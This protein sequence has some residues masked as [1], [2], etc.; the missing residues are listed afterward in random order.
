MP[1]S[2]ADVIILVIM[3]LSGLFA[4]LRGFTRE[5]LTTLTIVLTVLGTYWAF[6]GMSGVIDDFV[7]PGWLADGIAAVALIL[8]L[9]GVFTFLS[10]LLVQ[11]WG[12][13][14]PGPVD[15]TMG[16]IF[17]LARGFILVAL[18]YLFYGWT[19][20]P[21]QRPA[22]ITNARFLPLIEDTNEVFVRFAEGAVA[23]E[24]STDKSAKDSSAKPKDG[25]GEKG[26]DKDTRGA[27]DKLISGDRK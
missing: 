18:I 10:S 13:D 16:F 1:F 19:T 17:G 8:S 24:G 11:K 7:R 26:Y 25:S 22:W 9:Y 3:L 2:P 23:R 4:L 6:P 14:K 15:G 12:A 21:S 20:S 27:M 5:V